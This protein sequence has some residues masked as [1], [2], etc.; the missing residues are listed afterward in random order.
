MALKNQLAQVLANVQTF[1][2]RHDDA[3]ALL[4]SKQYLHQ[5]GRS[6]GQYYEFLTDV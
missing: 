2:L 3:F 6:R 4:A 5:I 1:E